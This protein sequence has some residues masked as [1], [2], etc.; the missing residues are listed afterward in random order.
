MTHP[1]HETRVGPESETLRN[2]GSENCMRFV[3]ATAVQI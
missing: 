1:D 3:I 2:L